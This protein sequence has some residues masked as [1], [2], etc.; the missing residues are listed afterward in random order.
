MEDTS[1]LP[2]ITENNAPQSSE[3][4]P[5]VTSEM[6][7]DPVSKT[8]L[9]YSKLFA[10]ISVCLL[11]IL[12][13]QKWDIKKLLSKPKTISESAVP[14]KSFTINMGSFEVVLENE[15]DLEVTLSIDC[16]LQSSCD[17]IKGNRDQVRDLIIPILTGINPQELQS[18]E[19]KQLIRNKITEKLNSILTNGKVLRVHFTDLTLEGIAK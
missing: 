17:F 1:E 11:L 5:S 15:Q 13:Y 10:S 2:E 6:K 12:T 16:S 18:P 7:N 9:F 14:Q 19:S 3:P 4:E 8:M